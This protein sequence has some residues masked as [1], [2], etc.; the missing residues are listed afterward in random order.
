MPAKSSD[1]V[2]MAWANLVRTGTNVFQ[3][4]EDELKA[5][6]HP[7]IAWYDVLW[8]LDRS[9]AGELHQ[10]EVQARVLIAQYNLV[11][12]LDRIEA[13]GLIR[14]VPCRV[15]GRSN[16]LQITE[17]GRSLRRAMWPDYDA[18]LLIT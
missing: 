2:Q 17:A 6:G 13:A 10:G 12:L 15:D 8:E 1:A 18:A 5:Q 3:R 9:E 11:R 16:I 4:I 14:R 7:P